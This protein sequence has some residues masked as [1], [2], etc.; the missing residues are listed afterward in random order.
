MKGAF[1]TIT[2]L[3]PQFRELNVKSIADVPSGD[4]GWQFAMTTI[5]SAQVYFGGDITPHT[6]RGRGKCAAFP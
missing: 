1:E 3:E 4:Y 2:H 6:A 5:N